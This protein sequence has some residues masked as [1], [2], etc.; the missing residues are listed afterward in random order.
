[1]NQKLE[2]YQNIINKLEN[3]N[4]IKH[5]SIQNYIKENNKMKIMN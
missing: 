2:E 5:N 4:K 1:M 3:E